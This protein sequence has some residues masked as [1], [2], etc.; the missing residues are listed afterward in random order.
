[1][2]PQRQCYKRRI[3]SPQPCC[4]G[5]AALCYD[6]I[7]HSHSQELHWFLKKNK[8]YLPSVLTE[9]APIAF[10]TCSL[11]K[12]YSPCSDREIHPTDYNLSPAMQFNLLDQL[13]V[14]E[15]VDSFHVK[16]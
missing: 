9:H 15:Q 13:P 14:I 3:Y 10:L 7:S 16:N 6:G 11:I 2:K 8:N 1:M 12:D 5:H 4:N